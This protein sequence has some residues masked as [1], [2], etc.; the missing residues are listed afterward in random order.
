MLKAATPTHDLTTVN[1]SDRLH[2]L[3][4]RI[5]A[6]DRGAFRRLYALLALPVWRDAIRA[7]PRPLDARAV[8]RSTFVEVWHMAPHHV[9]ETGIDNRAWIAAITARHAD[10]R[11]RAT[12]NTSPLRDDHDG[13]TRQELIALLARRPRNDPDRPRAPQ[14]H[15]LPGVTG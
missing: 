11:L 8:T 13:H 10:D 6:G 5:A 1:A 2:R 9:D 7:S 12:D 15:Q 14:A 3:V 4:D